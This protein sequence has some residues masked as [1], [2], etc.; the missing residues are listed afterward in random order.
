[1]TVRRGSPAD[2][3][4]AI[5]SYD[6]ASGVSSKTLAMLRAGGVD[7]GRVRVYVRD[8]DPQLPLYRDAA[9][10]Q[11]HAVVPLPERG[12]GPTRQALV[13]LYDP[14]TPLLQLDDDVSSLQVAA[15]GKLHPIAQVGAW[16]EGMFART[17]GQDLWVW[18]VAPVPNAF[19][20]REAQYSAALKFCIATCIG[21]FTRPGHPVHATRAP[22]KEDYE[23][24]LRAWWYDGAVVRADG[25]APKADHY[26]A[27]GCASTRSPEVEEQAVRILERDWPGLVRRNTRRKG[28][29][30]EVLLARR[31]RGPRRPAS[32]PLPGAVVV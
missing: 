27:G 9:R 26:S 29:Y 15:N 10:A 32:A 23:L 18:G 28:P 20:L 7:P 5:P 21:M 1:V 3:Q 31:P 4:V 22:V 19:F 6:R 17:A 25:V 30:P 2:Y 24:S 8:D 16:V 13:N 14:G 11:G 12:I